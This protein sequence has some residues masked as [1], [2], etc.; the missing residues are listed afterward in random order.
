[1]LHKSNFSV[2]TAVANWN[3]AMEADTISKNGRNSKSQMSRGIFFRIVCFAVLAV[4]FSS[5]FVACSSSDDKNSKTVE[6]GYLEG[7][8]WTFTNSAGSKGS[9]SFNSSSDG[10]YKFTNSYD[11]KTSTSNF[12]Y[13]Y[14]PKERVGSLSFTNSSYKV[15]FSISEDYKTMKAISTNGES[16]TLTR[17]Q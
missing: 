12:T 1:M 14:A 5:I 9:Y 17:V 13:G 10:V 4:V 16:A 6:N 3:G 15:A 2:E 8:L 11:G 7:S